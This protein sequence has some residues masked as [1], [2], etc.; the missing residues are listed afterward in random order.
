M[1]RKVLLLGSG[2]REHALFWK[3]SQSKSIEKLDVYP[4]NGGIPE[5]SIVELQA[6]N[7]SPLSLN[8]IDELAHAIIEK[9]YDLVIVGPEQPLVDGLVDR[10]SAKIPVFGP[11]RAAAQLEGSKDFSKAFMKRHNIPAA[12]ST[13][14]TNSA[15]ALEYLKTRTFPIV[16]KADGL[17]AGKGVVVARNFDDASQ[18]I[19]DI[20]DKGRFGSSGKKLL[21]EDFLAGQE[22]SVFAL[23]DGE[24][25]IAFQAAQDFKRAK[26]GNLG[27][28][29]G[30]MG[31]YTPVPFMNADVMKRV[32]ETILD[33][34]IAGMNAEGTPYRGLLYAGLMVQDGNPSV[35][36][37][38]CRFG[39]PETQPLMLLLDEDLGELCYLAA[40]SRLEARSLKFHSGAAMVVV[41][42]AQ[43]YP[44]DY[45]KEISIPRYESGCTNVQ[46]FHAGTRR[47]EDSIIST[48]GRILGIA[49][50]A[51]THSEAAS[52]VYSCLA[53]HKT[54]G[55]FYRSDIGPGGEV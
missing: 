44:D 1:S 45:L 4:G 17:A 52:M 49:A 47:K 37:F 14:F 36:E 11:V 7:G 38:N 5:E 10:L 48:G 28:N 40:A 6:A 16:I 43:G 9:Q 51:D 25:A 18:A 3:L 24:K 26:D 23:C 55:T 8:S 35:V 27:A 42:A 2:G 29:T 53:H 34:V 50:R 20:L 41:L 30:G 22:A 15:D 21:I 19:C 32:Q 33:R 31:A 54:E 39:D 12:N 13:T 46:V